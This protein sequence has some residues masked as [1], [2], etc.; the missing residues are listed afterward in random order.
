MAVKSHDRCIELG[1]KYLAYRI[2]LACMLSVIT[3]GSESSIVA[4]RSSNAKKITTPNN[5]KRFTVN[6]VVDLV[7]SFYHPLYFINVVS[8]IC[9]IEYTCDQ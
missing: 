1:V 8:N 2:V 4:T 5:I 3:R 9:D 7:S 6:Q